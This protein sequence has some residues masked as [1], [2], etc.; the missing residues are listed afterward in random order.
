MQDLI[1]HKASTRGNANHGWLDSH[2]TFSFGS[3]HNPERMHFGA[4]RVLNDD[5]VK[6]GMGFSKHPH[7]NMEIISIPLRGALKHNDTTGRNEIIK[8]GDVQIMSAGTGIS[9]SEVNASKTEDVN[10]LQLWIIPKKRNIAPRYE[11]KTFDVS[12]CENKFQTVV[13]PNENSDSL[14]INQDAWLS[15]GNIK[16][17]FNA[18]YN[19]NNKTNGIYVFMIEGDVMINSQMLSRRDGIGVKDLAKLEIKADSDAEL[20]VIEVPVQI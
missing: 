1:L 13:S 8:T 11:Q 5:I 7:D 12:G 10:F 20:L 19:I 2:H 16:K 4:L 3:Y 6:G 15:F 17:D 9:H 18:Y 14:W